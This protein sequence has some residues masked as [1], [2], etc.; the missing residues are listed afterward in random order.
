MQQSR[1]KQLGLVALALPLIAL[2]ARAANF[3]TNQMVLMPLPA[4]APIAAPSINPVEQADQSS[5]G[6]CAQLT[7][8][9]MQAEVS[10]LGLQIAYRQQPDQVMPNLQALQTAFMQLQALKLTDTTTDQVRVNYLSLLQGLLQ[11]LTAQPQNQ[12]AQFDQQVKSLTHF[13]REQ[14]LFN[15]CRSV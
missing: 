14:I 11:V 15:G 9:S 1:I 3:R 6:E 13:G 10:V 12:P 8:L 2:A 5:T 7:R 4:N